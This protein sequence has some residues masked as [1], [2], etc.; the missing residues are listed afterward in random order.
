MLVRVYTCQ[1]TT[2]LEITCTGSIKLYPLDY[3]FIGLTDNVVEGDW[4]WVNSKSPLRVTYRKWRAGEPNDD[5]VQ[6]CAIL[7]PPT[8]NWDDVSCESKNHY[9]CEV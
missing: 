1:N 9:I 6:N 8:S 7:V 3:W 4:V 2:L 5:G